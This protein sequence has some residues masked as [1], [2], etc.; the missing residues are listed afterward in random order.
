M[1][2]SINMRRLL[3]NS[4]SSLAEMAILLPIYVILAT[5][6]IYFAH[7]GLM[8]TGA[9][10]AVGYAAAQ[11][12]EQV[13]ADVEDMVPLAGSARITYFNDDVIDN[14]EM[15][16]ADDIDAVLEEMARAPL[17]YYEFQDG[18]IVYVL[19]ED[20]LGVYGKYIFENDL[21]AESGNIAGILEGWLYRSRA[22]MSFRYEPMFGD[23]DAVEITDISSSS[24]VSGDTDRGS[25]PAD[26][27][28]FNAEIFNMLSDNAFP[29]PME[30]DP[31]LW[32]S[33]SR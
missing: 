29:A 24:Y 4:G 6:A 9:Q 33:Q 25:H 31:A 8:R 11:R 21:Q 3:N 23:W 14:E 7:I 26:D 1:Q 10:R 22:T 19:D 16:T 27:P 5:A 13:Q 12:G 28:D 20:R 2:S 15:W 18:E 17:G 32:L 30:T